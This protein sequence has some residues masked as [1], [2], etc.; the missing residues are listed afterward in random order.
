LEYF[1]PWVDDKHPHPAKPGD[2]RWYAMVDGKEVE[3]A[4]NT[5]FVH[6]SERIQPK[7]RTFI[8][9]RLMDNPHLWSTGYGATLQALPEPLRSQVLYGNFSIGRQ[10]DAWQVIP[11]AWIRAAQARWTPE[12]PAQTRLSAIGVD[13]ARGGNDKTVLAPRYRSWFGPLQKYPGTATPD[14]PHVVGLIQKALLPNPQALVFI[15]VIGVGSSVVDGCRQAKVPNIV[16]IN[17]AAKNPF[18]DR[19]GLLEFANLRAFAYWSL[20][21]VLDPASKQPPVALP[22]D[23]E[24]LS[25]LAAG[26][27]TRTLQGIKMESKEEIMKRIGRSPDC[28]DALVCSILSPRPRG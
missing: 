25:D 13:V 28:G 2:L 7:S 24:L 10:D 18:R 23:R 6:N 15:D 3:R 21:D 8:P 11:T 9:A 12:P 26:R 16:A 19:T 4:D 20:R 22:P 14:G 1:G 27:W 5:P 17:F